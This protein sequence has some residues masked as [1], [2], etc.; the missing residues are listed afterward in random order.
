MTREELA[1]F[2]V[3]RGMLGPTRPVAYE[4]GPHKRL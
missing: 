2:E 1:A 3:I 4:D